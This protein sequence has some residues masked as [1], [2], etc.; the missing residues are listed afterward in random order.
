MKVYYSLYSRILNADALYSAFKKVNKSKGAAGI[1]RQSLS[2]Y[3]SDLDNNLNTLLI[4]LQ[5]KTYQPLPVKRVEIP[6]DDGGIRLLGIPAVRD[7]IVQQALKHV[8][9]PIFDPEF[10]PSSYGYRPKRSCHDAISKATLFIR[11]YRRQWV[12]DMDLS[13]CFDRLNHELILAGVKRRVTDGSILRLIKQFLDSGVMIGDFWEASEEGSPQGGVISPLLA[14]IYLDAFDQEMKRRGH[15]I[16]RYAD[17]ILILCNS[18]AGAKNA[19]LKATLILEKELKLTVNRTKTHI[20]HS[21]D[22][23]KF[24]GVEIGSQ[25]T[26]I[27]DK[28]LKRFKSKVKEITKRNQGRNIESV[29]KELNPVVRGFVNYFRIANCKREFDKL[30]G[31]IRRRLRAIQLKQWKRPAKLHRRLKQLKYKPPFKFIKMNSWR[32]SASPL[33]SFAMP[34]SWF[35]ELGLFNPSEVKTGWLVLTDKI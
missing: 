31:W 12:V 22:G 32:N 27:Q 35:T 7:R 6:K 15:R 19:L 4:E 29:I 11:E 20:A 1:D 3:A 14:N 28:K 10:H 26:R 17:D 2:D 13:K 21:G 34:N 33:S 24:L 18:Q 16:V 9:Q 8:L 25:Y 5:T 23:V 30:A